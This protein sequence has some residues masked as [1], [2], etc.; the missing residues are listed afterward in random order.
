[1]WVSVVKPYLFFG[2]LKFTSLRPRPEGHPFAISL[3]PQP[4]GKLKKLTPIL[5]GSRPGLADQGGQSKRVFS[6]SASGQK[7][8]IISKHM[9]F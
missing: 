3:H 2:Y 9:G 4:H 6:P 8:Q 5:S 7:L 1:M